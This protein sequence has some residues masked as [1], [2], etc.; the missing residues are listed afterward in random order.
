MQ[1][2]GDLSEFRSISLNQSRKWFL[3]DFRSLLKN[4]RLSEKS[5]PKILRFRSITFLGKPLFI[6]SF[7]KN[8]AISIKK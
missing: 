5:I 2:L 8:L 4:R 7:A 1:T 3:I 6:A